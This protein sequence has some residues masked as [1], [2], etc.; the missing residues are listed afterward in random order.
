[1]TE[2]ELTVDRIAVGGRALGVDSDGRVTFVS[3]A[4]PPERVLVE[5]TRQKAGHAEGTVVEVLDP[6]PDR[7]APPC[8]YAEGACGGC[9]WQFIAPSAQTRLR[10]A[11]V[12]DALRRVGRLDTAS[13][14]LGPGP[15]LPAVAYR[16]GV[17]MLV[18]DD[19]HLA[20][21]RRRSHTPFA[22]ERCLV[23]HPAIDDLIARSRFPGG[24]EVGLRA[25]AATGERMAVVARIT[26]G[27]E[28]PDDVVVTG[29]RERPRRFLHE[30]VAG[31]RLRISAGTF[32]Q[33][34]PAGAEALV[35]LVGDELAGRDGHLVDLY[36]GGGL[37][38]AT[39]GARWRRVTAVESNPAAVAD[40][41]VNAPAA[42]VIR[43]NVEQW[44]PEPADAVIADP[45]RSG[46]G[47]GGAAAVASTGAD[48][49]VLISCD[50][51]SL[52][53]DAA[54]LVGHGYRPI[55]STVLDLFHQT[56]HIEAVTMFSR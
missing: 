18:D 21:R 15:E 32:F 50:A 29:R 6:S 7:I 26:A 46:L 37:F 30:R 52:G 5:L 9:N 42:R 12:E 56:S 27:I 1:M 28:V 53:R 14:A 36:A 40:A 24:R 16:T 11:I 41:A 3:G 33:T 39:V 19:G 43:R 55:S 4:V 34:S 49:V 10:V 22:P 8:P 31:V 17:R 25:S 2:V 23:T 48:R 38:S 54:L 20:Y 47:H 51:A 44:R 35:N 45:S 13:I